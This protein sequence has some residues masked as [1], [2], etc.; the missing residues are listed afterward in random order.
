[1]RPVNLIPPEQRRG[2]HAPVRT[3][4][5]AYVVTGVLAALLGGVV[6]MVLTS[7]QISE[8]KAKIA[9]LQQQSASL[10][11]RAARVAAY[12]QFRTVRNQRTSTVASLANSRFDWER[13]LRELSLVLPDDVWLSGVTGTVNPGVTPQEGVS[14]AERQAVPG[15]ALELVGCAAG[16]AGVAGLVSA[17]HDID[18][19]TRVA[20]SKSELSEL[21]Q[22]PGA[23]SA[24]APT[25]TGSDCRTRSFIAKFEIV[26]AF[27]KAPVTG[28]AAVVP[29]AAPVSTAPTTS[30]GEPATSTGDSSG[31]AETRQQENASRQSAETQSEKARNA[32]STYTP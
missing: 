12:S 14:V 15:P 17:L 16:Q 21:T 28:E 27:D 20:V 4:R 24:A 9:E 11:A 13:V 19:V 30:A 7:N 26:V 29:T 8:R 2:Q 22:L 10:Q 18:G 32:V 5:M 23:A 31:V 6:L 25:T 3:G 1:V